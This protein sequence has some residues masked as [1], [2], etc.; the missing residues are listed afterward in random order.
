MTWLVISHSR[1][2][3]AAAEPAYNAAPV[4]FGSASNSYEILAKLAEGGMAEIFIARNATG[5]GVE[6][7]VVL[8]RILPHL[9][10]NTELVRMFIHEAKLAAQLQHPNIAQVFD[11]GKLG[12]SY[13]FTMEYVHGE[14]VRN[15]TLLARGMR[16][17]IPFGT[18]LSI[19]AGAAAGLHH[20]HERRGIDGKPLGIVHSDVSPSNI[21]ISREGIVK[22]VDFGIARATGSNANT[23]GELRGKISYLS[24]EQCHSSRDI[25]RRSDLFSL[26]IVLWELITLQGLY[27]R[28]SDFENMSAI[29]SELAL[30]PS[31]FRKDTPP[32]LDELVLKLLAKRPEDRF[33]TAGQLLES[34]E[35]AAM[36]LRTPLSVAGLARTMHEWFGERAEPWIEES[37]VGGSKRLVVASEPYSSSNLVKTLAAPVDDQLT[38]ME[39]TTPTPDDIPGDTIPDSPAVESLEKLRDRLLREAKQRRT[40]DPDEIEDGR[41]TIPRIPVD[42]V[43]MTSQRMTPARVVPTVPPAASASGS[44]S[45]GPSGSLRTVIV[46]RPKLPWTTILVVALSVIAAASGLVFLL[47]K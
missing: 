25:D 10:D 36:S 11:V 14:T 32:V 27:R 31:Q 29:E 24:P 28:S 4:S 13:F 15:L 5:A 9:A 34:I 43:I 30:P 33:Q 18:V 45:R 17:R 8:K 23:S 40:P 12:S 42:K 39:P 2:V 37:R 6:R 26:G 44:G 16:Q 7:I 20:A 46:E 22:V 38:T 3:E 19:A 47:S 41:E 21:L 1:E 35:A